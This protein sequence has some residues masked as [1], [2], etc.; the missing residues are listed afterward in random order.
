VLLESSILLLDNTYS[1]GNP[2][3]DHQMIIIPYV[4]AVPGVAAVPDVEAVPDVAAVPDVEAVD[5]AAVALSL[6]LLD[7]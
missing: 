3:E 7:H 6:F 4:E 2:H 5:V 1:T